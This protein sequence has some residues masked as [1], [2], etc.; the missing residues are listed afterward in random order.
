MFTDSWLQ[1][2]KSMVDKLQGR[3]EIE[4]GHDC[5]AHGRNK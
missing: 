5:L 1:G 4:E 3:N 2:V